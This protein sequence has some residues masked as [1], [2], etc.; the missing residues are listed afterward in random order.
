MEDLGIQ[1]TNRREVKA[2]GVPECLLYVGTEDGVRTMH[3]RSDGTVT[4]IHSELLGNAVRGIAVH[5][6]DPRMAYIA[7]GLRGW[8]LHVTKDAGQSFK[9][10][11]FFHDKWVWDV[12]IQPGDL[13]AIWVGTEPPML[14]VSYDSGHT[15]HSHDALEHLPSRTQ[16]HFFHAPFYAGHVHGITMSDHK[17]ERIYAGVEQGGLIYSL[18]GG[19]TWNDALIGKD[20]HRIAIKADD[21]ETIF[22]GA[23]DGLFVSHD[24]GTNWNV[25]PE[26]KGKYIHSIQWDPTNANCL[27][28]YA[29]DA[30][31]PLYRS[32]DGGSHWSPIGRGLPSAKPADSLVIHPVQSNI[33]IYGADTGQ[34]ESSLFMSYNHGDT[35]ECIFSGLPKIWRMKIGWHPS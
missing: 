32:V 24:A 33:L 26:L 8:G 31:C 9:A 13:S 34:R 30:N 23:G 5:P 4:L 15:F 27:Y 16:W 19:V 22:V 18:D 6:D 7:C 10:I 12:A 1:N 21:P 25:H 3:L 28:I 29:D 35:W 14:Y 20:I 17:P 2:M 11:E